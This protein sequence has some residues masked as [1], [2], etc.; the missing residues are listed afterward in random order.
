VGRL[1]HQKNAG[2]AAV[3]LKEIAGVAPL[4]SLPKRL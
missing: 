3:R 2:T 1:L 4:E